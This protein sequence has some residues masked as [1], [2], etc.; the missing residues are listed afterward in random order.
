MPFQKYQ[1]NSTLRPYVTIDNKC[2]IT[3]YESE[4]AYY[5]ITTTP[6]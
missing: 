1:V 3:E 5:T 6:Q 4:P 2:T